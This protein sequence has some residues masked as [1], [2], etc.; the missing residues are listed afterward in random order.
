MGD[1]RSQ[2]WHPASP[3]HKPD[4]WTHTLPRAGDSF[5]LGL[6]AGASPPG[7]RPALLTGS[8]Y[9]NPTH[10]FSGVGEGSL[11]HGTAWDSE[12]PHCMPPSTQS[13]S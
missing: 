3:V 6:W 7:Q 12:S 11:C 13:H 5:L 1:C 4:T 8:L 10:E 2:T 9:S